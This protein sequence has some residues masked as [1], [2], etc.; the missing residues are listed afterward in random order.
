MIYCP[1]CGSESLLSN[2]VFGLNYFICEECHHEFTVKDYGSVSSEKLKK[3]RREFQRKYEK[4]ARGFERAGE[5][6]NRM[7]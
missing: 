7:E 5:I 3:A 1:L 4:E 2:N 6:F